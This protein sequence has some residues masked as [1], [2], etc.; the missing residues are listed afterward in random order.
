MSV[1]EPNVPE[2]DK[3]KLSENTSFERM[4]KNKKGTVLL[5]GD[6]LARSVGHHLKAQHSMFDSLAFGGARIENINKKVKEL[7]D[8]E[9]HIVLTVGTNNLKS[10]ETTMIMSKYTDLVNQLKAKR[11]KIQKN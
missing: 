8:N 10:D 2:I 3:C 7:K 9:C 1:S 6:S 11:F 5:I 4:H